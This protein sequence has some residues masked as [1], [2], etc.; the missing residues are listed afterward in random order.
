MCAN[1]V[2]FAFDFKGP[3]FVIDTACSSSLLAMDCAVQAIRSGSCDAAV[4]GRVSL[5]LKPNTSVDFL[6]LNML[7]PDG[8]C[9]SFDASGNGYCHSECAVATYL[10][11]SS[12]AKRIYAHVVN[13]K[14]NSDGYKTQSEDKIIV[15][16]SGQAF[17]GLRCINTIAIP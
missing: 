8:A 13:S 1:R 12:E 11:K 14:A 10:T 9:K 17:V 4:V 5:T 6:R 16:S 3:S 7:S 2:S 15:L